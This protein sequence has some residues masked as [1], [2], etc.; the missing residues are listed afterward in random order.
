MSSLGK[1]LQIVGLTVL[2]VAML[3]EASGGL[4]RHFG[5]SDLVWSLGFGFAAFSLGRIIEGYAVS[6]N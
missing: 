4:A 1:A 2:P 6:N 3:L 5:V